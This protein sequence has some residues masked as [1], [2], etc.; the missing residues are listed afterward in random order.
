MSTLTS[1]KTSTQTVTKNGITVETETTV[2]KT[3]EP[4]G[5]I[6]KI[7]TVVETTKNQDGSTSTKTTTST[8]IK[9]VDPTSKEM[10]LESDSDEN[11]ENNNIEEVVMIPFDENEKKNVDDFFRLTNEHRQKNGKEPLKLDDILCSLCK[12]HN[13]RMI[14]GE[15]P[16]GHDGFSDRVKRIRNSMANAENICSCSQQ[17]NPM[18]VLLDQF[19]N[20]PPHN[21]NL[22]DDFNSVGI[23]V[24]QNSKGNWYLTQILAKLQ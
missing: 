14:S 10:N 4:T 12:E 3:A 5:K 11:E 13:D 15:I 18:N 20:D 16:L 17:P 21:K 8:E 22:L 6:T 19:I 24:G 9:Q 2:E 23:S 7:T 1:K